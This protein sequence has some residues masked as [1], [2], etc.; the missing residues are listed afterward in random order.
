MLA[1]ILPVIGTVLDRLIPD[2]NAREA[3]KAEIERNLAGALERSDERQAKVNETEV[4]NGKGGWRHAAAMLC[5]Y[6]L[7]YAWLGRPL[8]TWILS[9]V[10]AFTGRVV[11]PLPP[12]DIELQFTMLTGLLGLA[13]L[14]T[15]DLKQG[16]RR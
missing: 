16:T 5:V 4:S 9:L 2:V 6:S 15:L 1:A 11:P 14:R 10:E 7:G 3:A 8:A 13:G 12:V